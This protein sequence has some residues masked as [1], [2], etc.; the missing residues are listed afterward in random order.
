[1]Q[2]DRYLLEIIPQ[3]HLVLYKNIDR[4]GMLASVGS[5][6]ASEGINI[7]GLSLGRLGPGE[8]A[9]TAMNVDSPVQAPILAQLRGI[10]GVTEVQ[11][12]RL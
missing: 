9:M 11:A 10:D 5:L 4:P 3:G 12:V 7:A 8:V 1:V 2:I 6:L